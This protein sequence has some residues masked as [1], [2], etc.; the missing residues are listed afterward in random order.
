MLR[1]TLR[2]AFVS[3]SLVVIGCS[4][5]DTE[6]G[7]AESVGRSREAITTACNLEHV[8]AP[9]DP[10]TGGECAGVCAHVLGAGGTTVGCVKAS[11]VTANDGKVCGTAANRRSDC[12]HTCV[13]GTCASFAAAKNT[14]C[15]P[16]DDTLT[17][18]TTIC[19]GSCQ[20]AAGGTEM[21]CVA[22]ATTCPKDTDP[23]D[24]VYNFCD[25]KSGL[26][27]DIPHPATASCADGNPCTNNACDAFGTCTVTGFASS[28]TRCITG[29]ACTTGDHCTGTSAEC[30]GDPVVCAAGPECTS[31][32]C[33]E[34]TG[35]T[36]SPTPGAPC[37][38]SSKCFTAGSCST[39]GAC[40]PTTPLD[41]N[42]HDP[43]TTDGCADAT[44]CTHTTKCT[45][46]ACH[47]AKCDPTS[48]GC[49]VTEKNCDDGDPCTTDG[50]SVSA[51]GCTHVVIPGCGVDS[52][53]PDTGVADTGTI[54]DSGTTTDG[55]GGDTGAT[56]DSGGGDGG[57]TKDSGGGGDTGGS[58]D[59]AS[60]DGGDGGNGDN[61]DVN[62]S[63]GCGC[64]TAGGE[65]STR[66]AS[67]AFVAG[68]AA[69][70][71]RR[72]RRA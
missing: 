30:I 26:C 3:T 12:T 55:G 23:N 47:V 63:N 45:A 67:L 16:S 36:S 37:T 58:L 6:P 29:L 69:I 60:L 56:K 21:T 5:A 65:S 50:C 70:L 28:S 11:S 18:Q 35:C 41:C 53:V 59:G 14:P 71:A 49:S 32:S 2:L 62:L 57:P 22:L 33:V 38:P 40:T 34:P 1:L 27:T 68:A 64:R 9:C 61:A 7:P 66:F 48:G 39:T 44:G 72:R 46:D 42:D 8:G 20:L 52:G 13:A 4:S 19:D 10:G 17:S 43:C 24:C 31:T 15:K 54:A 25:A 51:G